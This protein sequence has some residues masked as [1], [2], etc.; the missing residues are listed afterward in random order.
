MT[1]TAFI[2]ILISVF[3]HA[4]WNFLSKSKKPSAAFYLLASMT[5]VVLWLP[6]FLFCEAE[7]SALPGRFWLLVLS[8]G[9]FEVLYFLGLFQAYRKSDI[10]MA[11]PLARA[12]PVLMVAAVTMIF[13]LGRPPGT[14]ALLGM[15]VVSIGCLLMPLKHLSEFRP[16]SYVNPAQLFIL[17]AAVGTTGYTVFDSL[18]SPMLAA[19]SASPKIVWSGAYLGMIELMI[20]AG[21]GSYVYSHQEE[22]AE[23]KRLFCRS[24]YPVICGC[25]ASGA[26]ALVLISLLFVSNVSYIQAFR[27]M[28]LP[29]GVLAGIFLLKENHNPLKLSGIALVVAGLLLVSLG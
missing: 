21:L 15:A 26:Y 14:A 16:R 29:L 7:W 23:F 13:G 25:F 11:Y 27:Q 18:A 9:F 10:S 2:L 3:L 5:S 4:G 20:T 1:L 6:F 8:S 28:S 19:K 24:I 22:R 12:M 17:L